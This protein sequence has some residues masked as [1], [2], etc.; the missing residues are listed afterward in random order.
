MVDIN[1]K[2]VK[3]DTCILKKGA[4]VVEERGSAQ[5]TEDPQIKKVSQG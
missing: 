3:R 1:S 2:R 5:S 4:F